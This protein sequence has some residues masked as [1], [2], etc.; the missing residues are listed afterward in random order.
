MQNVEGGTSKSAQKRNGLISF[1]FI[2]FLSLSLSMLVN[3][4]NFEFI[5]IQFEA[6]VAGMK[7]IK[8]KEKRLENTGKKRESRWNRA[9]TLRE[10][11][12]I[13]GA[14]CGGLDIH[15]L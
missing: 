2:P 6:T 15:P 13:G 12:Y 9:K 14:I 4:V 11:E 5:R 10:L 7:R 1:I 8:K 3:N